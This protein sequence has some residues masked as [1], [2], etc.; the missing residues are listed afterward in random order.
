MI[1]RMIHN[2][3]HKTVLKAVLYPVVGVVYLTG[4]GVYSGVKAIQNYTEEREM[5]QHKAQKTRA[6]LA[7]REKRASDPVYRARKEREE[8]EAREAAWQAEMRC[9]LAEKRCINC[10]TSLG[11]LDTLVFRNSH[12]D[13]MGK[14]PNRHCF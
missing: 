3:I 6:E 12:K 5:A 13:C 2:A 4:K 8:Q 10:G 9:R 1:G 11:F 7:E 14:E